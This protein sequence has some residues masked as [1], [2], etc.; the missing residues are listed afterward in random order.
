MTSNSRAIYCALL[1]DP[2]EIGE[3][4][5]S[6][7]FRLPNGSVGRELIRLVDALAVPNE[8]GLCTVIT[9]AMRELQESER[10]D[11]ASTASAPTWLGR[12]RSLVYLPQPRAGWLSPSPGSLAYTG[13]SR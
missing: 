6:V 8:A 3:A 1:A 5:V 9:A 4:S 13:R 2:V 10:P 7:T 11:K 12:C